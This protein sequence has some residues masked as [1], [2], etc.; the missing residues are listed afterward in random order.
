MLTLL[1]PPYSPIPLQGRRWFGSVQEPPPQPR[2]P[3]PCPWPGCWCQVQLILPLVTLCRVP[4]AWGLA[5][6]AFSHSLGSKCWLQ[7]PQPGKQPLDLATMISYA[8][9]QGVRAMAL[10]Q[11]HSLGRVEEQC[12][13]AS[14]TKNMHTAPNTEYA[15]STQHRICIQ[16]QIEKNTNTDYAYSTT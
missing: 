3:R 1:W 14:R 13:R 16:H 2:V 7:H 10:A 12:L 15:Y 9:S 6:L 11:S 4:S 8:C 5:P